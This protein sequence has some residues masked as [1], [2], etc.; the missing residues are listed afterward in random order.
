[1]VERTWEGRSLHV[2]PLLGPLPARSSQGEDGEL[3]AALSRNHLGRRILTKSI[4]APAFRRTPH[5]SKM[6][7]FKLGGSQVQYPS[8]SLSSLP[9]VRKKEG[10]EEMGPRSLACDSKSDST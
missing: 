10:N 1:M 9:F 5:V 8:S 6:L 3:D 2:S 7:R 4:A